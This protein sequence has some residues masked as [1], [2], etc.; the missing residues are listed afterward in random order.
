MAEITAKELND[1]LVEHKKIQRRINKK[2]DYLQ[3]V[4]KLI[5]DNQKQLDKTLWHI[6]FLNKTIF[7]DAGIIYKD[8]PNRLK[9]DHFLVDEYN[10]KYAEFEEMS[11]K[12]K[13]DWYRLGHRLL[14]SKYINLVKFGEQ[15]F[16]T[17]N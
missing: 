3:Q 8:N 5:Q 2:F 10:Q 15:I 4:F 12:N 6:P 1:F 13:R 14:R 16:D 9:A 11:L 17:L 7:D